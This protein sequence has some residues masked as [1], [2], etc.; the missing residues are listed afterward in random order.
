MLRFAEGGVVGDAKMFFG[1]EEL[2][3]KHIA[4]A[5]REISITQS[6]SVH[7]I[8]TKTI[9]ES[10]RFLYHLKESLQEDRGLTYS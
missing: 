5:I 3:P 7:G 9:W 10:L 2:N 4:Q 8:W 1:R 6:K